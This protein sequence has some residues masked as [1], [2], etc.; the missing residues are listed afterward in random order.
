MSAP[1]RRPF[2]FNIEG[3]ALSAASRKKKNCEA[4]EPRISLILPTHDSDS[5][6]RKLGTVNT[7]ADTEEQCISVPSVTTCLTRL[8]S[9]GLSVRSLVSFPLC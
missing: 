1:A 4:S 6:I 2:V 9:V 3:T 8:Q 5:D 7:M